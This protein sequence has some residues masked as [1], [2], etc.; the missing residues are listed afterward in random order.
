M[1]FIIKLKSLILLWIIN[2]IKEN[3]I[4]YNNIFIFIFRYIQIFLNYY[5]KVQWLISNLKKFILKF[6]F[7]FLHLKN[8]EHWF[9]SKFYIFEFS[10][11]SKFEVVELRK[12]EIHELWTSKKFPCIRSWFKFFEL[13]SKFIRSSFEKFHYSKNFQK[14]QI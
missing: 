3:L 13:H 1:V 4:I 11:F 12:F 8:T 7:K 14:S 9:F 2:N 10:K 6:L 5:D